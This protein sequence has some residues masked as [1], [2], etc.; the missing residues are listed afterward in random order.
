L[1]VWMGDRVCLDPP[2]SFSPYTERIARFAD[3]FRPKTVFLTHLYEIGRAADSRWTRGHAALIRDR[4]AEISPG[5][6]VVIPAR[7]GICV[8]ERSE[9]R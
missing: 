9:T 6:E 5:T 2:E 4:I 7:G 3:A 8:I 1:H